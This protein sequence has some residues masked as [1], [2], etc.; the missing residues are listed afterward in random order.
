MIYNKGRLVDDVLDLGGFE[1]SWSDR[2]SFY[3]GCSFTFEDCLHSSGISVRNMEKGQNVSMYKSG[4]NLKPVGPFGGN[5]VVSMRT[6]LKSQLHQVFVLS[7]Q[8][9]TSHGAPIHIGNPARIGISDISSPT[10]GVPTFIKEGEV[11]VFWA[12]G[13]SNTEAVKQAGKYEEKD[14]E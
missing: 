10:W 5:M 14:I 2:T 9:P 4:I 8:Y 12:C 1:Q 3:L 6:I 13:V 7:A 11:P